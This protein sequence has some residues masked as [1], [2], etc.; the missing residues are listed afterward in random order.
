MS[1]RRAHSV[2]RP[3][4]SFDGLTQNP[5]FQLSDSIFAWVA[6]LPPS[7]DHLYHSKQADNSVKHIIA[8]GKSLLDFLPQSVF[9]FNPDGFGQVQQ[10]A[11]DT[12]A[13]FQ[14]ALAL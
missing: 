13:N 14:F 2:L 11:A 5:A 10:R 1:L 9:E 6:R 4:A 12:S 7:R 3:S 8:L